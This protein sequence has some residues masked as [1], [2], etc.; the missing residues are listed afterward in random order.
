[1]TRTHT[2]SWSAA[3]MTST[4]GIRISIVANHQLVRESLSCLIEDNQGLKVIATSGLISEAEA[5]YKYP[6]IDIVVIYLENGD[7]VEAINDI[8]ASNPKVKVVAITEG[9][10]L[11]CST[12]ALRYG[13]VGIVRSDQSSKLLIE[14]IRQAS[15][16][17]TWLNQTLLSSLIKNGD[18]SNGNKGNGSKPNGKSGPAPETLTPREIEVI[19]M[20]GRG[21]KSKVIAERLGISEATV[22]HHLSSIY[23]KLD[24]DD[25]LNLVIYAFQKGLVKVSDISLDA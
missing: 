6:D 13:A 8:R 18:A 20:I 17:E 25:R 1:M 14:A 15:Q 2:K 4:P 11:D 3:N 12:M 24:V 23:G 7:S 10:A 22:R 9:E 19:S 21:L 16:G 5:S